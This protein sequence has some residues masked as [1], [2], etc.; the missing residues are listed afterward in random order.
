MSQ[1]DQQY[2]IG[3]QL[4]ATVNALAAEKAIRATHP[5]TI[6]YYCR[7][8]QNLRRQLRGAA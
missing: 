8:A 4:A 7:E 6:D 3:I 2:A 5:S 1:L